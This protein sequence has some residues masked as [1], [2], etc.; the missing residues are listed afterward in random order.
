MARVVFVLAYLITIVQS[1]KNL[2]VD[3]GVWFVPNFYP[4][5]TYYRGYVRAVS[6]QTIRITPEHSSGITGDSTFKAP[7]DL[8]KV[9]YDDLPRNDCVKVRILVLSVVHFSCYRM[10]TINLGSHNL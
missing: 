1:F 6:N 4:G 9:V 10:L 2:N 5:H 7:N 8:D 3:D